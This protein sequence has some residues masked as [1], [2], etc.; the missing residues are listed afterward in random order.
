MD[1][2]DQ[3]YPTTRK[4]WREWLIKNHKEKESIWV[5][6]FRK[7]S[8]EPSILWSEAVDEALCFGWIDS[9]KVKIN[10]ESYRQYYSKRKPESGWSK[11]NKDKVKQLIKSNLM[12]KAG[13]ESIK[14]AKR[15]G[16]W[17]L[18]DALERLEIPGDLQKAF[19]KN[20]GTEEKF[21]TLSK[22]AKKLHLSGLVLAKTQ[23]TRNKRILKIIDDMKK[24]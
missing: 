20:S 13:Y 6:F 5:V 3:F 15:N 7:S 14:E 19:D 11:I 1:S 12:A 18:Y 10:D 9:K 24:L 2:I 8:D 17:T 21:M 23:I 16:S 4:E 22:S